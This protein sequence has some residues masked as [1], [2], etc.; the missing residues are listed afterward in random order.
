MAEVEDG[1]KKDRP[2]AP[3]ERKLA[4]QEGSSKKREGEK[5]RRT[6]NVCSPLRAKTGLTWPRVR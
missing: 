6:R 3:R 5:N 2:V 1:Q 4:N